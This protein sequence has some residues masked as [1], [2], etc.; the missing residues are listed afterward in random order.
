MVPYWLKKNLNMENIGYMQEI[1]RNLHLHT[2]CEEAFC[3]NISE[4][5]ALKTATFLIMGR[6]CTRN[7]RFC[8]VVHHKPEP[9][10]FKEPDM[11]VQAVKYLNLKYVV[12]TSVTRDDL[13]DFGSSCF[14][15]VVEKLKPLNVKIELL[16][17][18]F[19]VKTECLQ[20]VANS[21]AQII[22]HN[23]ETVKR[24]YPQA[25]PQADYNRSLN[26]L[27]SL[28]HLNPDLI[29]KSG[30]MVG[31]GETQN[32]VIDTM[33][34]IAQT[35]CDILT[36]GQYLQPSKDHL[37]VTKFLD[38]S[39]FEHYKSIAKKIGFKYVESSV[40]TRSSYHAEN[41][42]NSLVPRKT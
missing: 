33:N 22:G 4:C 42:Y 25:R 26:V 41:A 19:Q 31:L 40:F 23:I 6:Y 34:D 16:I 13:P 7:C 3:P 36:I 28:K 8:N 39:E 18:D 10:N 35:G 12:I 24:L 32:E 9:I 11:I 17:P 37:P 1:L 20:A 38:P 5:F 15:K 21:G 30:I 27:K 29:T 14:V 2:V